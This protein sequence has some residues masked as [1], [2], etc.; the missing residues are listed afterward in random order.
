[1]IQLSENDLKEIKQ[2]TGRD[3]ASAKLVK[4]QQGRC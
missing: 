3:S 1:M 2:L 4:T